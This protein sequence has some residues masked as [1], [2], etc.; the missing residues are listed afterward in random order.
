[1]FEQV[2]D[3]VYRLDGKDV[4]P[5]LLKSDFTDEMKIR[6]YDLAFE[7]LEKFVVEKDMADYIKQV[8]D[9]DF[10]ETWQCIVGKDFAVS[11]T[12]ESEN[13]LFFSIE[14]TYF[15]IFKI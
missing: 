15:L 3:K 1:M 2:E 8:F 7:S 5:M 13:F 9:S 4:K 10:E 14:N 11:L 12:H 6:A